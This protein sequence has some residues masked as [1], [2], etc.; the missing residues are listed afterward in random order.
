MIFVDTSAWLALVDSRDRNHAQA[1]QIARRL[2]RG[3][4]GKQAT[5]NYMLAESL[6]II[7]RRLGLESA[8]KFASGLEASQEVRVFW[9]E[10][11]HHQEA[12]RLMGDRPDKEWSL[13]DCT[14]FV[15]MRSLGIQ[16]AF[17]FDEDYAQAGFNNVGG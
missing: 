5:T 13:F 9:I 12:I 8:M 16:T 17:A 1:V 6:T 11:V 3:E 14:S 10:P 7:R 2:A 4:F 15:V